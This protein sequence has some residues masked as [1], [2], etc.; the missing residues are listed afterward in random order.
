MKKIIVTGGA[1]YIGS[2]T[3]I[4]LLQ[5]G[6][7]PII[8]DN[9]SNSSLSVIIK[10]E[11]ITKKKITF[12]KADLRDNL[13]IKSILNQHKCKTVIHCAG[14]KSV[15]ESTKKPICYFDNNIQSTI[16]LLKCMEELKIFQLI[17]SS[18]ATVYNCDETLPWN[19]KNKIGNTTNS[20]GTSKYIIERM[21][22]DIS[23]SNIKWKI[24]IARYFNP[25]G[26]HSSGLISDN[27]QKKI[28]NLLPYIIQV[29]KKKLSYLKIYGDDYKTRDGTCVRDYIHVMDIAQGHIAILKNMKKI[30][31]IEIYNFG[32][33]KG[34]T[35]LEMVKI[36]EKQT[37]IT[38]PIKI[39]KRRKGD[40]PVSYC[41]SKKALKKLSWRPIRSLSEAINDIKATL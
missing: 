21:L 12:Y 16:S 27:Y 24:G 3:V 35:V 41:S 32:T 18:S 4:S 38:I 15:L 29:A 26:N 39:S 1:G 6:Y 34:T 31:G 40:M 20:Y 23:K 8:I 36:F 9:F 10:L 11:R 5:N 33:G 17:F 7:Y 19:E 22:T 28:N 37:R 14:L 2:H 13:K 30:Q 25:I